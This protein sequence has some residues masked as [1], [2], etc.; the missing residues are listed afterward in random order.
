MTHIGTVNPPMTRLIRSTLY[1]HRIK[2]KQNGVMQTFT[3]YD[4]LSESINV[5]VYGNV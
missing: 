4:G 5:V 2:R 3:L 1:Q